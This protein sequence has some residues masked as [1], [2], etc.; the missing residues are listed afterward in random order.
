MEGHAALPYRED[1]ERICRIV[2]RLVEEHVAQAAAENDARDGKEDQVIKLG[3]TDRRESLPDPAQ[4]QPPG[5]GE[6]GQVH[7]PVPAHGERTD[8]ECDWI[9]VGMYKHRL[10]SAAPGKGK[11]L[12]RR[13]A[14]GRPGTA[15][16]PGKPYVELW[17]A[18]G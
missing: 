2:A 14:R 1:F 3:A 17:M 16:R 11:K 7:E 13:R 10:R 6:A 12:T 15:T 4:P 5:C 8:R 9:N 18:V